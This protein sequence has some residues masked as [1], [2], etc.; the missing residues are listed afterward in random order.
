[1]R[2]IFRRSIIIPAILAIYLVVMVVMGWDSF[3]AGL[4]S[5][6]LYF[7][8]IVVVALCI[9]LLHFHFKKRESKSKDSR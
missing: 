9:I 5:P 7:G 8:G 6:V 1:M 4:T 2:Q 3:M